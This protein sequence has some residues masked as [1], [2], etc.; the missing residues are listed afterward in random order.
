M[1]MGSVKKFVIAPGYKIL[2]HKR[3]DDTIKELKIQS[4]VKFT[5]LNPSGNYMYHLL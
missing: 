1:E 4:R 2:A 3:S 5:P